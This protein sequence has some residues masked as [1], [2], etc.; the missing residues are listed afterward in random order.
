SNY[1]GGRRR[2]GNKGRYNR[3]TNLIIEEVIL[4]IEPGRDRGVV[5]YRILFGE[6]YKSELLLLGYIR[7]EIVKEEFNYNEPKFE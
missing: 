2:R 1:S 4:I 7:G 6:A 5:S 3:N